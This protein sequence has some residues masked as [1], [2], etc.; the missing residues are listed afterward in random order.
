MG[1]EAESISCSRTADLRY[2]GQFHEVE[3]EAP[4]GVIDEAAI[5]ATIENFHARHQQLYTFNMT[6]QAVEF[7]T[8]RLRATTPRAP[9]ELTR[10]PAA[11]TDAAAAVARVG[12]VFWDGEAWPTPVYEGASLRAGHRF[13]GPAIVE[14]ATTSVVVPPAYSLEV[15]P[16]R[17][18]VMTR[19]VLSG[20]ESAS[21]LA[22]VIGG[23][24]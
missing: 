22:A 2:L 21:L 14:E 12:R 11:E 20:A 9:F 3:V 18:Y 10:I 16:W 5:G 6:W 19:G 13:P 17:N 23:G 4:S 24:A 15:D 1:V 8:F 7:L